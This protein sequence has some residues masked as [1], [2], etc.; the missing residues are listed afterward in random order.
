MSLSSSL[1]AAPRPVVF[2]SF[3]DPGEV[4]A[5][6][7]EGGAA[8]EASSEFVAWFDRSLKAM[9]P[10]GGQAR[11]GTGDVP[12]DW[13]LHEAFRFFCYSPLPAELVLTLTDRQGMTARR[14]IHLKRGSNHIQLELAGLYGI[15]LREMAA[16]RLSLPA[17]LGETTVYLDRF[18]LDSFNHVLESRGRMDVSYSR[19][20]ATPHV[21][22][23]LPLAGGPVR[24]LFVPDVINGRAVIELAQRLDLDFKATT[25]GGS[26]ATNIW[27]FGDFYGMRGRTRQESPT[28]VFSL[29]Y[30]YLAD[31]LLNG[32][33]YDL[34]VI[35]GARPWGEYPAAV[36][37]EIRRRVA[38]GCGLVLA[39]PYFDPDYD[40]RDLAEMS[41]LVDVEKVVEINPNNFLVEDSTSL[42]RVAWEKSRPHYITRNVPLE[43]FPFGQMH[44]ARCRAAG[45]VLL[46]CKNPDRT[47]ILA[48]RSFG[49]GRVA[50]FSYG[51]RGMIP[52]LS[53]IWQVEAEYPYWEYFYSLLIRSMVWA[54][55]RESE[56]AVESIGFSEAGVAKIQVAGPP[57]DQGRVLEVVFRDGFGRTVD[58]THVAVPASGRGT[59]KVSY[60]GSGPRGTVLVDTRLLERQKVLDWGSLVA[61]LQEDT[62]V[63]SIVFSAGR[64]RPGEMVAGDVFLTCRRGKRAELC[65]ELRDNYGRLL[66]T[67]GLQLGSPAP[68]R[69]SFR[70]D[71]Q[72]AL[73]HLIWVDCMVKANGHRADRRRAE[74]FFQRGAV[75][76]DYDV[77][78][79]L[80]GP[81]PMPGLWPT[82][83]SRLKQ[84]HTTT[85]SSYPLELCKYAN[86]SVQAQTRISGQESPDGNLRDYYDKMKEDYL[87]TGDKHL[88]VRQY[89][90]S[91]PKYLE[92][93]AAELKE[94]CAPW[95]PFSPMSYYIYEE[96]S[97]TCYGD[98]C[99][100]CFSPH[101]MAAMRKWLAGEYGTLERLNETWETSFA[102]WDE[103]EPDDAVQAQA[104]GSYASW[105]D[106]RT[107]MEVTYAGNCEYVARTLREI[108]PTGIVLNSGTQIV[109][110][111]NGC[112]YWRL[113]RI[114]WHLN[115]Y[116]GDN[117]MDF[118]RTFGSGLKLS[119]GMGYG[120][121]GREVPY[122]LYSNLFDG[123]WAGSYVFWQYSMLD[124]DL[125][126][127]QSALDTRE[128]FE[129]MVGSGIARLFK[130]LPRG[131][132]N[133]AIHYSMASA[134]GTWITDGKMAPQ[135]TYNTSRAFDRFRED[136]DGWVSL[137]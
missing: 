116:S 14:R 53:S 129:E 83:E 61:H 109:G 75:W 119:A 13:H 105:A 64:F 38:D 57:N 16:L 73:S 15:N 65:L 104:R 37:Q 52:R 81:D 74:V 130:N 86:F 28:A 82:I 90:L 79:Y 115:P 78:M 123:S 107:F 68:P 22:W 20:V 118:H 43:A 29:A 94:L 56:A 103:V 112:D 30:T 47:P 32:P 60:P 120:R 6:Q 12:A 26:Y 8:L 91:D 101:C 132:D 46:E 126:F 106:H 128:G 85:L 36:R 135:V 2:A 9:L 72:G 84:L 89:C 5:W 10:S 127:C 98:A 7:A 1:R 4:A 113:D 136:R 40:N 27:G 76:D 121:S 122:G 66:D 34:I 96:P 42:Y 55:G 87:S 59:L 71:P 100:I 58:S 23:A 39:Y 67:L 133:I 80:F 134:H 21:P 88:L 114:F 18:S 48:V 95:V 117:Q 41:P 97:L 125:T 17:G 24:A 44:Y 77:V 137:L 92:D 70:L 62:S 25:L 110:S 35:P 49:K 51:E 99:D 124:P 3:E 31:E 11:V 111:H 19:E 102:S 93:E 108:D 69:V 33:R 131:H 63:D 54:A 45:E 50:A